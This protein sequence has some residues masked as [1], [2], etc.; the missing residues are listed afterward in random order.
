MAKKIDRSK[1]PTLDKELMSDDDFPSG[2][3]IVNRSKAMAGEIARKEASRK[4]KIVTPRKKKTSN[5]DGEGENTENKNDMENINPNQKLSDVESKKSS[6][7]RKKNSDSKIE[8]ISGTGAADAFIEGFKN[9]TQAFEQAVSSMNTRLE[10]SVQR[11]EVNDQVV[12]KKGEEFKLLIEK[13]E[14]EK[15]A[16]QKTSTIVLASSISA[17]AVAIL[18]SILAISTFSNKN[19]VFNSVSNGLSNRIITMNEGLTSFNLARN[20]LSILQ[21]QVEGLELKL[22]ESQLG[23]INT[24]EDIQDQ[25]LTYTQDINK[26]VTDQTA[27][28]RTNLARLDERFTVFNTRM[29]DYGDIL[30][31]SEIKLAEVSSEAKGLN[32]LSAVL[33]ALLILEKERY[34]EFASST[35]E[36]SDLGEGSSLLETTGPSLN[37]YYAQ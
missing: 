10:D 32:E 21:D 5:K 13:F 28:L 6:L 22:E 1:D 9:S 37:R 2:V 8:S 18:F 4:N 23:Y 16:L 12:A 7:T 17:L 20:Q 19:E 25:L 29:L 31:Q 14:A 35:A 26:K 27:N 15:I 34:F 3:R 36:K 30:T 33:D 11:Q 24:E